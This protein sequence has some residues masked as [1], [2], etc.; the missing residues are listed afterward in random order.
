MK[1]DV[2]NGV[3]E[4]RKVRLENY[5]ESDYKRDSNGWCLVKVID[6]EMEPPVV[7]EEF[8]C[9]RYLKLCIG[10]WMM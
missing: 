4:I 3:K 10:D 1:I 9:S 6:G 7:V 2:P 8:R 5:S